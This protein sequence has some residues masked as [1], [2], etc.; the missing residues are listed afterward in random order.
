MSPFDD[1]LEALDRGDLE[2][3]RALLE[4]PQNTVHA[5]SPSEEPTL[6]HGLSTRGASF[7]TVA[8][9]VTVVLLGLIDF[10]IGY[11]ISFSLFYLVPVSMA[12]WF[13]G[14]RL[15]LAVS[16]VSATTWLI[17]DAASGQT[18]STPLI[19]AWNMLI[20]FG[21]FVIV[22]LLL[23][24]LREAYR[25]EREL[26]RTDRITGAANSRHFYELAQSELDRARRFGHPF[27]VAYIDLDNFK[28]VNDRFGHTRGDEVLRVVSSTAR[29]HLRAT[30]VVARI[31]GD[32]FA[33]LLS[34]TDPAGAQAVIPKIRS[35]LVAAMQ[36]RRWPVTFSIGVVTFTAPP[37]SV[38]AMIH[39][40]DELMYAVKSNGKNAVRYEARA[41]A[42]T[43]FAAAR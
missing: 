27:T 40:A 37:S 9:F 38:D 6:L 5:T 24:R 14:R 3:L 16:G 7:W 41:G 36:N 33:L 34:G 8:S 25:V 30:D 29:R 21:F 11:E 12:G 20:R 26:A 23:A 10:L 4:R 18:F 28:E 43:P 42:A 35:S 1:A 22:M 2:T 32:E 31:G 19:G 13:V 39:L 17:A 15:G